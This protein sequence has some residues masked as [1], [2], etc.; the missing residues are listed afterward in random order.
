MKFDYTKFI[1]ANDGLVIDFDDNVHVSIMHDILVSSIEKRHPKV[2]TLDYKHRIITYSLS[3]DNSTVT[4]L[5]RKVIDYD[6]YYFFAALALQIRLN[7]IEY[8][9]DCLCDTKFCNE[10]MLKLSML[11][12]QIDENVIINITLQSDTNYIPYCAKFNI[13]FI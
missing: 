10:T 6:Y 7:D 2:K 3:Y 13:L 1:E 12:A 4:I 5:Q 8:V 11:R 9:F